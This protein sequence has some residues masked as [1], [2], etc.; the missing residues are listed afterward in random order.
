[1][2]CLT[3]QDALDA[4]SN[5]V[6]LAAHLTAGLNACNGASK[7]VPWSVAG[8]HHVTA[9][10]RHMAGGVRPLHTSSAPARVQL[11][12]AAF[13]TLKPTCHSRGRP[14]GRLCVKEDARPFVPWSTKDSR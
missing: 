8:K 10:P 6:L 9:A 13:G 1:M 5:G 7:K 3:M 12:L 2:L 4:V 11:V 14:L